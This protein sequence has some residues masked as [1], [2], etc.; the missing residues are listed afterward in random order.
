MIELTSRILTLAIV[1]P[2]VSAL[3]II[4]GYLVL[5]K[6]SRYWGNRFFAMFFWATALTLIFNLSY[7]FSD[8]D[9][10]IE[11]MNLITAET[12]IVGLIGLLLGVLIIYLL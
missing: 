5:R 9:T 1:F 12:V 10:F 11:T 7:L 4:L 2:I 6:D 3:F 8:N